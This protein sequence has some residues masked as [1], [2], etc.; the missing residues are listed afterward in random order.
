MKSENFTF[1]NRAGIDL[2]ARIYLPE[3]PGRKGVLFS[4]GLYSSKDGY[5]ITKMAQGIVNC[6]YTLMTFD[7]TFA[8]ESPGNISDISV[9]DEASDLL[10]AVEVFS[11]RGVSEIHL[12]GS[13][14]G[15]AV[16]VLAASQSVDK[17]KSLILIAT[18]IDL[19]GIIPDMTP[20]QVDLLEP[21]GYTSVHGIRLKN[22]FFRE[23][24]DIDMT[25]AVRNIKS[26]VLLFHGGMDE[27][28]RFSNHEIFLENIT[29]EVEPVVIPDGD[30]NLTR[31]SDID[32]MMKRISDWLG[33]FND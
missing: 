27:V 25:G 1:R 9:M 28:V 3:N 13:S 33:R 31:E 19:L 21:H 24:R 15:A 11:G 8:G 5:K 7:F 4:H 6:G 17:F 12:M 14:M 30:H 32:F 18:P 10:S 16:S 20:G 2:A 26:P 22:S 29:A 23:L